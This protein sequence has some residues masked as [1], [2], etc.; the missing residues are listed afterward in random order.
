MY[1]P[2][3][4]TPAVLVLPFCICKAMSVMLIAGAILLGVSLFF[5][6]KLTNELPKG[7]HRTGWRLLGLFILFFICGYVGF[8]WLKSDSHYNGHDLLVPIIFFFGALFVLLVCY[9][10]YSTTKELK[11]VIELEHETI[12]DPL[13]G[14]CNRRFIDRRLSEEVER[15][16]R[17]RLDLAVMLL[18]ID[19]FKKVNDTWG[20][21]NG[22]LVLKNIALLLHSNL[23]QSDLL[24][25]Y[26]GEEFVVVSPHTPKTEVLVVAER[27]RKSVEQATI[28]LNGEN[29]Q[30][31]LKVTISI[32]V[33]Y[34]YQPTDKPEELIMRADKALYMAKKK[35]RNMVLDCSCTDT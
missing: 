23:R 16:K 21:Q 34:L 29:G 15:A 17:H 27:L 24:A 19:Y 5:V 6:R 2:G 9:M 12:T 33:S 14:I 18:D 13:L 22:D 31:E 8:Y 7:T 32:G 3:F 28:L 1:E 4:F 11:R 30:H 25:R 20:H 26:G 10:A 35:G